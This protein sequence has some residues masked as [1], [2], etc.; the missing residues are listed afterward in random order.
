MNPSKS[1]QRAL[2]GEDG[3]LQNIIQDDGQDTAE[4]EAIYCTQCGT[5]NPADSNFC[6]RCGHSLADQESAMIGVPKRGPKAKNDDAEAA[7]DAHTNAAAVQ[8]MTML[9]VAVMC[10]VALFHDRVVSGSAGA[11]IPIGIAWFLVEVVRA[12]KHKRLTDSMAAVNAMTVLLVMVIVGAAL[13]SGAGGVSIP[14]LIAWFLIEAIR[15]NP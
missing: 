3:E 5:P 12:E 6:R 8:V 2:L 11:V 9:A 15:A 10:A 14:V 1:R 13:L 4:H 7:Q